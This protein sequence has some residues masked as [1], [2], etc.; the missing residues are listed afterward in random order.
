MLKMPKK[1][2]QVRRL[3]VT[4]SM[5]NFSLCDLKLNSGAIL[6]KALFLL[7]MLNVCGTGSSMAFMI[8]TRTST[9]K[10]LF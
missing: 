9:N 2:S 7:V 5:H 4:Y 1:L 6:F 8:I 10:A 3:S